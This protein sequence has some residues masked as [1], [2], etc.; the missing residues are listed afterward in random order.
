MTW[1]EEQRFSYRMCAL[2]FYV[3]VLIEIQ[4]LICRR[5]PTYPYDGR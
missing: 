3:A 1:P 2:P 5:F 4:L